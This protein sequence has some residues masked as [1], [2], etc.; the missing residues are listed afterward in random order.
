VKLC[1]LFL[2]IVCLPNYS[3][4][5]QSDSTNTSADS[6]YSY[7]GD[8]F[9]DAED[10]QGLAD[11]TLVTVRDF[12]RNLLEQLKSDPDLA[13][14]EPPTV[15]ETLWDRLLALLRQF[16][17]SLFR[18]AVATDWGRLLSYAIGLA[19]LV[20]I[21]MMLLKVNAFKIFYK[22][23]GAGSMPY[24]ILDEN[25]HEM[26][27]DKLI[28]EAV[29]DQD[30]RRGIRLIFLKSLKMLADKNFI[31]W[32][33]GKTNHDYLAEL[34]KEDLKTGFNELN[35]YFEYA[36]YGNFSISSDL[37]KRVQHAFSEW[38]AGIR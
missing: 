33:H 21:I 10:S 28:S 25:I 31:Q 26:D 23:E 9:N 30:Y 4:G 27:F 32:E 12:D 2:L 5:Q 38:S 34:T 17:D 6:L 13:Y 37:F 11:S 16:L 3:C 14:K 15:A 24:N 20:V 35:Y 1:W 8:S 29:A 19:L 36:W 7:F 22:G 18:N